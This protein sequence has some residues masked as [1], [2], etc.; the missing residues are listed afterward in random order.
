MCVCV[1]V[2]AE[3]A[4]LEAHRCLSIAMASEPFASSFPS[5]SPSFNPLA[6]RLSLT[7]SSPASIKT[8]ALRFQRQRLPPL[9]SSELSLSPLS[10]PLSPRLDSH[11]GAARLPASR[12]AR[13]C[14]TAA[15]NDPNAPLA[16]PCK[17]GVR[18]RARSA[19]RAR[20]VRQDGGQAA[21]RAGPPARSGRPGV[22][23]GRQQQAEV[24]GAAAVLCACAAAKGQAEKRGT[25]ALCA[26]C[27]VLR[28]V[29][30]CSGRRRPQRLCL[31]ATTLWLQRR[32]ASFAQ[33]AAPAAQKRGRVHASCGNEMSA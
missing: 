11:Q 3:H 8:A 20:H 9:S 12:D 16:P 29:C 30:T 21:P 31:A 26:V 6:L 33:W 25:L 19:A 13:S 7:S 17:G 4:A 18:P 32:S 24:R 27:C 15:H 10:P 23:Q 22:H 2:C 1:C 14:G 28:A 5:P